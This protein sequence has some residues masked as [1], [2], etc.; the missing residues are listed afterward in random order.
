MTIGSEILAL[1]GTVMAA[2]LGL[3]GV[4]TTARSNVKA[5]KIEADKPDWAGFTD[6]ITERLDEQEKRIKAQDDMIVGL[7]E[8]VD[9]LQRTIEASRRKYWAAVM[10]IRRISRQY[11]DAL[12]HAR[13]PDDIKSDV[14]NG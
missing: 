5:K 11:E 7:R 8:R 6:R 10:G 3:L 13:L 2:I 12:D 4:M 1:L 9:T 14:L